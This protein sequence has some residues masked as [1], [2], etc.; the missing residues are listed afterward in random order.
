M[1][2]G[3]NYLEEQYF[4]TKEKLRARAI[5]RKVVG[6]EDLMSS[7]SLMLFISLILGLKILV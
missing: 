6:G 1:I 5:G 2:I 3:S 4:S 7:E